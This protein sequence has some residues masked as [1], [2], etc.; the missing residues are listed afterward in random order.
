VIQAL[1]KFEE[2]RQSFIEVEEAR[3]QRDKLCD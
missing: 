1:Y 2:L 3:R